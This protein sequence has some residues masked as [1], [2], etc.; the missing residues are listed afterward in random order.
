MRNPWFECPLTILQNTSDIYFHHSIQI[1]TASLQAFQMT[2]QSSD[3]LKLWISVTN[4]SAWLV[5]PKQTKTLLGILTVGSWVGDLQ[6][7]EFHTYTRKHSSRM[8]TVRC[9]GRRVVCIPACTGQGGVYPRVSARGK[10]CL[11]GEGDVCL[12]EGV[13]ARGR[14]CLP[15]EVG[16][17]ASEVCVPR[18]CLPGGVCLG[19]GVCWAVVSAG[20]GLPGGGVCQTIFFNGICFREKILIKAGVCQKRLTCKK[21]WVVCSIRVQM[22][23]VLFGKWIPSLVILCYSILQLMMLQLPA[24]FYKMPM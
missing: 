21:T 8:R 14:G 15:G 4:M 13:S 18:G 3:W 10:G 5:S 9:S 24:K 20:G 2:L 23:S 11:A 12:G 17:S 1:T 22:I 19:G 7:N 6:V 16:V